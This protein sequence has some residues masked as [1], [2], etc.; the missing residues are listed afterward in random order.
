MRNPRYKYLIL[1]QNTKVFYS[2]NRKEIYY[3]SRKS[4]DRMKKTFPIFLFILI[5][6]LVGCGQQSKV[7]ANFGLVSNMSF[8]NGSGGTLVAGEH[9]DG[10]SFS[11]YFPPE[12]KI[13]VEMELGIWKYTIVSYNGD[14]PLSGEAECAGGQ[15][16]I[17]DETNEVNINVNTDNCQKAGLRYPRIR[18]CTENS[19]DTLDDPT[20]ANCIPT[21]G[22]TGDSYGIRSYQ[23]AY[24]S[25]QNLEPSKEL[26]YSNCINENHF[27][28]SAEIPKLLTG[29][30]GTLK[31]TPISYKLYPSENCEGSIR[32]LKITPNLL[33]DKRTHLFKT[34]VGSSNSSTHLTF[35]NAESPLFKM[36]SA[37]NTAP[38]LIAGAEISHLLL[39]RGVNSS[40]IQLADHFEDIENDELTYKC[41]VDTVVDNKVNPLTT[42]QPCVDVLGVSSSISFDE[43]SGIFN[44]VPAAGETVDSYEIAFYAHDGDLLSDPAI[45]IANLI[46]DSTKPQLDDLA[47][48]FQPKTSYLYQ[49]KEANLPITTGDNVQAWRNTIN[50]SSLKPIYAINEDSNG[51]IY[52]DSATGFINDETLHFSQNN[53]NSYLKFPSE[54]IESGSETFTFIIQSYASDPLADGVSLTG[55]KY[56]F[57]REEGVTSSDSLALYTDYT[58]EA[59]LTFKDKSNLSKSINSTNSQNGN[60]TCYAISFDTNNTIYYENGIQI[61][62]QSHSGYLVSTQDFMIGQKLRSHTSGWDGQI[63]EVLIWK[64]VLSPTEVQDECDRL[65]SLY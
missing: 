16:R 21:G 12:E 25:H 4:R 35:F 7:T 59:K 63:S 11:R 26:I 1:C 9:S 3:F 46:D 61:S 44:W 40:L 58:H 51:P 39:R 29:H 20:T 50:T 10:F 53:I 52:N 64:K 47:V 5:A 30:G 45:V 17:S 37:D 38:S 22:S 57:S 60:K 43:S 28:T 54:R 2:I 8:L 34:K 41:F 24:L 32:E 27:E 31:N 14:Y 55:N 6:G 56:L 62:S 23:V 18:I 15:L 42:A 33:S 65:N 49:D 36:P 19:F 48:W 13:E